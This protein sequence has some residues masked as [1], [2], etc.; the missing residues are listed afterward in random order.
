MRAAGL[1]QPQKR[2]PM[3]QTSL[4]AFEHAIELA[5]VG[6]LERHAELRSSVDG[7]AHLIVQLRQPD[8][9]MPL[10]AVEH[11]P[12]EAD[13]ALLRARTASMRPGAAVLVLGSTLQV[14]THDGQAVL[15]LHRVRAI[16][17]V[18]AADYFFPHPT[19]KEPA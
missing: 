13:Q 15:K 4:P 16:R 1:H 7:S 14:A 9:S 17:M 5:A 2:M 12:P 11:S 19:P 3:R 10:V 18:D 6:F 8:S